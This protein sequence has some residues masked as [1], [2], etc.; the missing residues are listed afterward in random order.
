MIAIP[1]HFLYSVCSFRVRVCALPSI[2]PRSY[3]TGN[4]KQQTSLYLHS[5]CRPMFGISRLYQRH[6]ASRHKSPFSRRQVMEGGFLE[7][8]QPYF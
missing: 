6:R 5:N 7:L 3:A 4:P 8:V 2:Q 1:L